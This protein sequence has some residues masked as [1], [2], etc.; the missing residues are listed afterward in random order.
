MK[1][2]KKTISKKIE[3]FRSN[4]G[5]KKFVTVCRN[6]S[7]FEI[8][9]KDASKLFASKFACGSSVTDVDEIIVQ[10]DVKDELIELIQKTWPEIGKFD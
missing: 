3:L 10:G 5:K 6:L 8:D 1:T 2:K 9:L 7:T 4:R